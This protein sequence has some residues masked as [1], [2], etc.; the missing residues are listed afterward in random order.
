GYAKTS[1]IPLGRSGKLS[2][3]AD[4]VTYFLSDRSSYMTG[5]TVNVSGGKSRG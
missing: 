1:T 3:V 4:L 5:Q 2:E